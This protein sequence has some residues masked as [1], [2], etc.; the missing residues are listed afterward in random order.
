MYIHHILSYDMSNR[1]SVIL[2]L[3]MIEVMNDIRQHTREL[4][5][6]GIQ[7]LLHYCNCQD[8]CAY[9]CQC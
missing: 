5:F 3:S 6:D 8:F 9:I 4:L 1:V 2:F 7:S